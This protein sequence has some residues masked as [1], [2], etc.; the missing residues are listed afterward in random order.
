MSK[1]R[2]AGRLAFDILLAAMFNR[3]GKQALRRCLFSRRSESFSRLG[4]A[5][6]HEEAGADAFLNGGAA[7]YKPF[8]LTSAEA[9]VRKDVQSGPCKQ[10]TGVQELSHP[11]R[12]PN[13]PPTL[14]G[15]SLK[16]RR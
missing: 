7:T 16:L 1:V 3:L 10:E 2:A 5:S 13:A 14:R 12:P 8:A 9:S 11:A 6:S 15:R 4:R